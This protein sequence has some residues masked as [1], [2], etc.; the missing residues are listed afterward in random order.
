MWACRPQVPAAVASVAAK[1]QAAGVSMLSHDDTQVETR[2]Y[3]RGLGA[4]ITEFPM[5]RRVAEAARAAGDVIVFG[6]P[7]AA[8]GGSHLGSPGAAD[9][10]AA[11]LCDVL[12]S[13]YFYPAMLLAMARLQA[14]RVAP[15][16]RLWPLISANPARAS[17]L[18]DRGEIA[19]D[20]RADLMVVAWPEGGIPVVRRTFVAGRQAYAADA[21]G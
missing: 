3:F 20:K 9:M 7:N 13:D 10:I 14:D 18:A 12:A 2:D 17:G 21:V 16:E 6:A 4:R 1:G 8:G 15:L 5:N 19:V 11:S